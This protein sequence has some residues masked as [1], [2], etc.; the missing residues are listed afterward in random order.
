[1]QRERGCLRWK[2]EPAGSQRDVPRK[3]AMGIRFLIAKSPQNQA[4]LKALFEM[5]GWFYA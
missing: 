4:G 3:Y 1:M 2:K 5:T